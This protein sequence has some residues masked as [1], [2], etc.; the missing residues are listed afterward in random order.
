MNKRATASSVSI[1]LEKHSIECAER[2]KTCFKRLDKLD[3]DI[4]I[5]R[6]WII[7]GMGSLMLGLLSFILFT[8]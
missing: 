1:D 6:R 4:T 3:G 5:I 2:W 8:V 7:S